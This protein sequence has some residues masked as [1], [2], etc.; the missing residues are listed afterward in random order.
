M[1]LK[2]VFAAAGEYRC[3]LCDQNF[4]S[5]SQLVKHK[6]QHEE[7]KSFICELCRKLFTSQADLSKHQCVQ[8]PSFQCNMCDRSF[9]SSHNLKRHKLLHVKDGRKCRKCGVLFCR[10]HNHILF[11]PQNEYEQDSYINE[12]Q[13]SESDLTAENSLLEKSELNQTAD[14]DDDA[15]ITMTTT[16]L[17]TT[18]EQTVSPNHTKPQPLSEICAAPPPASCTRILT[19][20]PVPVMKP[21]SVPQS[22]PPGPKCSKF[23]YPATFVQPHLPQHP[24]LPSS[25][26]IFSPQYLT[27]A[28]LDVQRNYEYIL[29]KPCFE[30]GS[31]LKKKD[32]EKKEE[33]VKEEECELLLTPPAEQRVKQNKKERTAYD[34]EIVL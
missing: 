32:T 2:S 19:E 1:L 29:S 3:E 34:L 22:R 9:S 4:A 13:D 6:Q 33:I 26:Q 5:A 20:I 11:V 27:S 16:S 12:P 23:D 7:Q 25:L 15:Q 31:V 30:K 18:T 21:F 8:E 14:L 17:S 28:L 10:R 24:E